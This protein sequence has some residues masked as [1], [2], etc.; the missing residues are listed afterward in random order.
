M[1]CGRNHIR[2]KIHRDHYIYKQENK[3]K[4]DYLPINIYIVDL[5]PSKPKRNRLFE[6]AVL[7]LNGIPNKE[8]ELQRLLRATL[9]CPD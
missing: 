8:K 9:K 4:D 3:V 1:E 2:G 5:V 6:L 7:R